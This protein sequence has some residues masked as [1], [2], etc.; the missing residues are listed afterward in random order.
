MQPFMLAV[1]AL[2]EAKGIG[3]G[4]GSMTSIERQG[5]LGGRDLLWK[6]EAD[7]YNVTH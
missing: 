7:R 3:S 5:R 4:N 1:P 6:L 2:I